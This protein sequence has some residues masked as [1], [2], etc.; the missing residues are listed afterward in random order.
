M[1]DEIAQ[2]RIV[3]QRLSV[4]LEKYGYTIG[5]NSL[6]TFSLPVTEYGRSRNDHCIIHYDHYYKREKV[7][8]GVIMSMTDCSTTI[9][10]TEV[11]SAAAGIIEFKNTGY[12]IDQ[13]AAEMIRI[14]GDVPCRQ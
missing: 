7:N 3:Y 10:D 14:A 8:I 9:S 2:N 13:T 5:L 6:K 4:I 1:E 12:S 11:G